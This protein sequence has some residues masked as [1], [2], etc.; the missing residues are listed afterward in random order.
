MAD[1]LNGFKN[2]KDVNNERVVGDLIPVVNDAI[3]QSRAEHNFVV[4][5]MLELFTEKTTEHK[6]RYKTNAAAKLQPLDEH[7]R[8]RKVKGAG[9]YDVA[10]PIYQAGIATGKTRIAA[11]KMTVQEVNDSLAD[12]FDA[13][14]RWLKDSILT[15]LFD[16]AGY[17]FSDDEFGDL[18]VKGLAN[19]DGTLYM[20]KSGSE[21]GE[22][23]QHYTNIT[24]MD[25]ANQNFATIYRNL[26]SRPE[27]A[28]GGKVISFIPTNLED[29]VM[30]LADFI[31]ETDP[32]IALGANSDRLIATLG[33]TVPGEVIGKVNRN[34]I[35]R[36]DSL[37][38]N[39]IVS[40]ITSG[41]RPLAMREYP[42]AELRGFTRVAERNDHPFFET[43]FDRYAGFGA[44]NR[45]GA[46]ITKVAVSYAK[47]T[48]FTSRWS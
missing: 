26:T 36:W 9:S 40:T 20:V 27:N 2:L 31:E 43:Q 44:Y 18:D 16:N 19:T 37:P 1:L 32:D 33:T 24:A 3:E 11:A 45:L 23:A 28:G 4:D 46:F 8:A 34:W 6:I 30:A 5:T 10:F 48:D 29:D 38:D 17:T 7:G 14:K 21:T 25:D 22:E 12:L 41:K 15:A 35:V 13:D 42:E 39:Y 47:P